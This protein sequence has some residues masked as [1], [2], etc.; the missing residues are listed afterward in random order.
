MRFKLAVAGGVVLIAAIAALVNCRTPQAP[1]N[2]SPSPGAGATAAPA[3]PADPEGPRVEPGSHPAQPAS[4]PSAE[5]KPAQKTGVDALIEKRRLSTPASTPA[6]EAMKLFDRD[7]MVLLAQVQK[8]T[9]KEPPPAVKEIMEARRA[10][11]TYDELWALADAKLA[12]DAPTLLAVRG[13]LEEVVRPSQSGGAPRAP[14]AQPAQKP[15]DA[16][17]RIDAAK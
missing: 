15:L 4:S 13:W 12:G 14:S 17:G 2:A 6:V 1:A 7:E 10:G 8:R 11:A 16:G 9:G 5:Q 3:A